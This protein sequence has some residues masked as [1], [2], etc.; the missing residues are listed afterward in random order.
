MTDNWHMSC[1]FLALFILNNPNINVSNRKQSMCLV[2]YM[3]GYA[4]C[5]YCL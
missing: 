2:L 4:M 5:V 1:G 3:V